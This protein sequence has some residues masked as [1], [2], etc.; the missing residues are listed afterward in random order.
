M[1]L[2]SVAAMLFA[3]SLG[4][5]AVALADHPPTALA[6]AGVARSGMSDMGKR[7]AKVVAKIRAQRGAAIRLAIPS[8]KA[9][10]GPARSAA[11]TAASAALH[12]PG[13]SPIPTDDA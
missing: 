6:R 2:R 1:K 13:V 12:P 11:P 5:S 7:A 3:A 10:P 9:A 8:T 4:S